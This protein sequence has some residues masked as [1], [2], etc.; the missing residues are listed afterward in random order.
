MP[1]FYTKKEVFEWLK[2]EQ[3]TIDIRKGMPKGGEFAFFQCGPHILKLRI[4]GRE[5]GKLEEVVRLDNFMCVVPT[6]KGIFEAWT[7]LHKLYAGYDG[8]F[9]AYYLA[10]I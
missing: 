8:V 3:K 2:Q 10:S 6:A 4:V 1:L 5:S 7:Y 9:T